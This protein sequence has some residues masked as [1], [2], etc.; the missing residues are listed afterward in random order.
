[1]PGIS[2]TD[3]NGLVNAE[4]RSTPYVGPVSLW[5]SLHTSDPGSVGSGEVA[6]G[7]YAR[8]PIA[9]GAPVGGQ[10]AS[11]NAVTFTNLPAGRFTHIALWDAVTGGV[12]RQSGT[13]VPDLTTNAG[14][15]LTLNIGTVTY[16]VL[17]T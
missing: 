10:A 2:A 12:C 15:N 1:V 7:G 9:F 5:A 8:Q 11:T 16:T 17:A 13:L 3:A 14:Q 6:G 4:V